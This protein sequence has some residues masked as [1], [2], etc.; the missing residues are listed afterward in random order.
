MFAVKRSG[1]SLSELARQVRDVP[2]RI[3]PYAASTALTRMARESQQAVIKR[4]P[5]VFDRPN[6]YTLNSLRIVPSTVQTLTAQVAVKDFASGNG[7]RPEDYLYPSVFGGPR[8]EKRFERALRYN[9]I[10]TSRERAVL[11]QAAPLDV[12]GNLARGEIQ[13]ILTA[14]R[15]TITGYQNRSGSSRS[16]RN[17]RK[18]PYFAGRIGAGRGLWGIWRREGRRA[19]PVMIFTERQ[20][21]YR[22]RLDFEGIVRET[23]EAGFPAA[24]T[25]AAVAIAARRR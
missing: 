18:A 12:H 1:S 3:I 17:A 7:T 10:I 20:P 16:R 11:G 6:A 24:F 4:M 8:R 9:G 19:R 25:E 13:K 22:R 5:Q 15:G 2:E 23:V 14:V 21:N